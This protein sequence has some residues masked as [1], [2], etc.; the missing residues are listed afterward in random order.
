MV[1]VY[2]GNMNTCWWGEGKNILKVLP[3]LHGTMQLAAPA[4]TQL[5]NFIAS[6]HP[7]QLLYVA[8]NLSTH[9]FLMHSAALGERRVDTRVVKAT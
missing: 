9:S 1:V 2:I 8:Q 3:L 5:N 6:T 4:A 7:S